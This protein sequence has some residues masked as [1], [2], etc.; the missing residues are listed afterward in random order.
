MAM[1]VIRVDSADENVSKY[2]FDFGNAVVHA[3][4]L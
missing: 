2:V 1:N 3:P 4:T